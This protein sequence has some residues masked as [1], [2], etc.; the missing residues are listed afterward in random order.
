MADEKDDTQV[1]ESSRVEFHYLK[2]AHLRVVHVDGGTGGLTPRGYCHIALYNERHAIPQITARE[3][4]DSELLG[5]EIEIKTRFDD[6][7]VVAGIV[8]EVEVD[9]IFD[10][11]TAR[12]LREW[13]TRR[14]NDFEKIKSDIGQKEDG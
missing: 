8:R 10:E 3:V 11:Q 13:L 12:D 9:L 4:V 1:S 5:P 2:S 6:R 7:E 14:L